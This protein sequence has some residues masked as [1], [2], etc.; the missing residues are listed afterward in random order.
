M[1]WGSQERGGGRM[2]RR[3]GLRE[4][5]ERRVKEGEVEV[6]EEAKTPG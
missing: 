3:E 4:R 1:R 2:K 5:W 6:G